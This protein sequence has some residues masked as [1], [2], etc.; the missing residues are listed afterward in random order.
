MA[1]KADTLRSSSIT[2]A[3]VGSGWVVMTG[4]IAAAS[5]AGADRASPAQPRLDLVVG[6]AVVVGGRVVVGAAVV[7]GAV[8]GAVVGALVPG[9]PV[10][11]GLV[12]GAAVDGA[13]LVVPVD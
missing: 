9:L 5:S 4:F 1:R 6:G 12:V 2:S 7:G 13:A 11:G 10:V 3:A 8:V